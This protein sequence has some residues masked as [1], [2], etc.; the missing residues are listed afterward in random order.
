MLKKG[1]VEYNF[2]NQTEHFQQL[3]KSLKL[4]FKQETQFQK[5][6]FHFSTHCVFKAGNEFFFLSF[7]IQLC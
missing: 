3:Y 7:R 5:D 6:S 2:P 4:L 1:T